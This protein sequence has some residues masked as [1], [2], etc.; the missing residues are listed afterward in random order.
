MVLGPVTVATAIVALVASFGPATSFTSREWSVHHLMYVH[1]HEAVADVNK[2]PSRGGGDIPRKW[3]PV[4]YSKLLSLVR[5]FATVIG[6]VDAVADVVVV[7]VAGH[8]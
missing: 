6:I 1:G 4:A 3:W 5:I 2:A 7:V 8:F